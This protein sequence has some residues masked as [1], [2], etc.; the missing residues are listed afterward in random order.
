VLVLAVDSSPRGHGRTEV[1]LGLVLRGAEAGGAITES[2]S[3]EDA[4]VEEAIDRVE[5]ADAVVLG[6]PV[7]RASFAFPLKNFL[8]HLPRGLWGETAAPLRG[9]AAV[10]VATGASLHHFLALD[11]MRNVLSTFFAAHVVPPGIY[12]P[13]EGFEDQDRLTPEFVNQ[14][15]KQGLALV[16]LTAALSASA[17]LRCLVPQA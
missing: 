5:A 6:T 8:D 9:K 16:E 7:Y 12:V 2:I 4:S 11:D 15:I 14:A 1:V 10:I 17:T 13:R 3:L